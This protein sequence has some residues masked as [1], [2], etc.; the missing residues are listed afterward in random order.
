M[1]DQH[2]G[3]VARRAPSPARGG[4]ARERLLEAANRLF[5]AQGVQTVGIDKVIEEA[6]V[7]RASLYKTFGSKDALIDAYLQ[8]RHEGTLRNLHARLDA[9][10]DP[11]ARILAV[12]DVQAQ[13]FAAPGFNGCA[14]MEASA[15]APPGGVIDQAAARFRADIRALLTGYAREAG[16]PDP[17]RLGR[18]L[19]VLYDGGIIAARMDRD[20]AIAADAKAAAARLLADLP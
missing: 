2:A 6:G 9:I 18:Q 10:A 19:H 8:G 15:E 1:D 12:F 16:A 5:Y 20:P 3:Q 14:F 13:T 7:A 11:K 4:S 17:V